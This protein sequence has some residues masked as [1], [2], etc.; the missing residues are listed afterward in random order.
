MKK[1]NVSIFVSGRGTNAL[2]I[3]D[4]QDKMQYLVKLVIVSNNKSPIIDIC[5]SRNIPFIILDKKEFNN[6]NNIIG[7]LDKYK[8]D[9]ICLAGFMWKV[10]DYLIN[11]F[12]NKILNIHPSLLPK[13]GGKVMYGM[14]IHKSVIENNEKE[15]GLTIHLVNDKYDEGDIIFQ[16]KIKISGDSSQELSDRIIKLEHKYYPITLNMFCLNLITIKDN[17]S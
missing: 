16:K 3:I 9:I 17:A 14:N 4:N 2:S 1:L 6:T 7:D 15:S 8:I 10:P 12:D 13:Y 5:K 11:R